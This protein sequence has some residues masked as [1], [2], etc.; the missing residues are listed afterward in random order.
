[1][2]IKSNA[3]DNETKSPYFIKNKEFCCD[4]EDYILK[5]NGK[6]KGNFN[7]WSYS[8]IGKISQSQSWTLKYKKA[9][10][11]SGHLFLSTKRQNVLTSAE[12]LTTNNQGPK[13][14]IRQQG[15]G[16]YFNLKFNS[17]ISRLDFTNQYIIKTNNRN[18]KFI[19]TLIYNL[20]PLFIKGEIYKI[21][22]NHENLKIEL[23]EQQIITSIFLKNYSS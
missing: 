11:S 21:E 5:Q 19:N 4:F 10:F 16:D 6:V 1:M 8:I 20:K 22:N 17:S 15:F 12:W 7:A 9:T 2:T 18:S 13:F 14:L 3:S 23:F